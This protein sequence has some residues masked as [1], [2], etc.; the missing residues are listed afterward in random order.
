MVYESG[1][2]GGW[3]DLLMGIGMGVWLCDTGY[4]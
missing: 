3:W 4:T 1:G 2:S